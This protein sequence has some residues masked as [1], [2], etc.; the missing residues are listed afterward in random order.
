MESYLI[1]ASGFKGQAEKVLVPAGEAELL[2]IVAE[3]ARDKI[4]IT[5]SGAGTGV[6]GGRVAQS[7]WVVSTGEIPA[8][9]N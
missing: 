8:H 2:S 6:T 5:I 3:A 4:P 9:R 7:G 1:D